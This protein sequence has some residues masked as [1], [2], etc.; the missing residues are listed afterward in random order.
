MDPTQIDRINEL[1]RLSKERELTP[2]EAEERAELR[3]K[4]LHSFRQGMRQTLDNTHVE[5]PDGSRKPLA[6]HLREAEPEDESC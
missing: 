3:A 4:Y 2:E 1:A 5:Y 6:E